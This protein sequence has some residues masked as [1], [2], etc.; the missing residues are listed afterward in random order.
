MTDAGHVDVDASGDAGGTDSGVPL[1]NGGPSDGGAQDSGDDEPDAN[2]P[3][4]DDDVRHAAS[5]YGV[6]IGWDALRWL[7]D[8]ELTKTFDGLTELKVGFLRTDL[9]WDAIQPDSI[10]A[11]TWEKFDE[12]VDL[13]NAH[14]V[15]MLPILHR[16]PDWARLPDTER[17]ELPDLDAF[18]E[19]AKVAAARYQPKGIFYW[20]VWNEPNISMFLSPSDPIAYAGLLNAGYEGVKAGNPLAFVISAGLAAAPDT[21][22]GRHISAVD[23]ARTLYQHEPRLDAF[24]FHPYGWPEPP[25]S[26]EGWQGW[27]MMESNPDNL[28]ALMTE[29]GDGAKR[30]WLTEYGAPTSVVS[31]DEQADFLE[32]AYALAADSEWAG[33]LF[34]YSFRD[35]G[36]DLSEPEHFYGL[37]RND[38]GQK[39]GYARYKLMPR[40]ADLTE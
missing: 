25:T 27:R 20:E 10:D 34:Y 22:P 37:L 16:S 5:R 17:N 6:S 23:F 12:V 24:G 9:S 26:P 31:E 39:P 11:Y 35:I 3:V 30:I 19:F 33:P 7:S 28:R 2:E 4:I 36:T 38:W 18:R 14:G 1:E 21:E 13:A 40:L 15:Q 29:H 8:E 32:S